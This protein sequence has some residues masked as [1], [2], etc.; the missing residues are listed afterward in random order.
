MSKGIQNRINKRNKIRLTEVSR[1]C[2]DCSGFECEQLL[3]GKPVCSKGDKIRTSEICPSFRPDTRPVQQSDLQL[4]GT[5]IE[6]L[7]KPALRALS[8][9]L[10]GASKAQKR[11]LKFMQRV[12]VR[13]RGIANRNYL[14]NFMECYILAA[15]HAYIRLTSLDGRCAL[16]YNEECFPHIFTEEDFSVLKQEMLSK[17]NLVDPDVES[18]I[19]RKL[20]CEE[21]YELEISADSLLG[22]VTTI[23]SVFES[24]EIKKKGKTGMKGLVAAVD[25]VVNERTQGDK[26]KKARKK[27]AGSKG[28]DGVS[29]YNMGW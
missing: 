12:Y 2:G 14:S 8:V 27:K 21:E 10:H 18:L 3:Q 20:R 13:Y 22:E 16:T 29:S 25:D 1:K 17:G 9:L 5:L 24:N 28:E 11:G 26:P 4:I 23:D 19:V 7:D 6:K 15:D